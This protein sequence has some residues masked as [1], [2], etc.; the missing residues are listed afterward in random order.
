MYVKSKTKTRQGKL[1]GYGHVGSE[2]MVLSVATLKFKTDG[3][4][5]TFYDLCLTRC[6]YL[7]QTP[8]SGG[9]INHTDRYT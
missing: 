4:G 2:S 5:P 8:L 9:Q 3:Y 1:H 6:S 7:C